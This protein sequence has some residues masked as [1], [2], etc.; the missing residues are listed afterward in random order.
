M[1]GGKTEMEIP[2]VMNRTRRDVK[3]TGTGTINNIVIVI[4]VIDLGLRTTAR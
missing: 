3:N 2:R 4:D 1:T